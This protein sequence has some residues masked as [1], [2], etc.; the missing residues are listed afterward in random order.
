MS[1]L[2]L[3]FAGIGSMRVWL[4]ATLAQAQLQ[5]VHHS[6]KQVW[7]SSSHRR[8]G[9]AAT[10]IG[11]ALSPLTPVQALSFLLAGEGSGGGGSTVQEVLLV[12]Q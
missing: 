1:T 4:D 7:Q 2:H 9:T 12:T 11:E 6:G 5:C 10:P 3:M 8:S